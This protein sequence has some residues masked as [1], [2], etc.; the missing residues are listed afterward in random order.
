MERSRNQL[1]KDLFFCRE[2]D[3]LGGAR[4]YR[5]LRLFDTAEEDVAQSVGCFVIQSK[6]RILFHDTQGVTEFVGEFRFRSA[7]RHG[8]ILAG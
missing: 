5:K 1:G 8:S 2:A 3:G 4:G 7:D 6:V